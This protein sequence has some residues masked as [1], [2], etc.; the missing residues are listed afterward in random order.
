[1][2]PK[3]KAI[4]IYLSREE[5]QRAETVA[6]RLGCSIPSAIKHLAFSHLDN[7]KLSQ[8]L[9]EMLESLLIRQK[10]IFEAVKA[11]TIQSTLAASQSK[12]SSNEMKKKLN[13]LWEYTEKV[14]P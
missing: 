1:M 11:G 10:S 12:E 4:N 6:R 8:P 3:G 9:Q 13:E 2:Q 7:D 5:L 14:A